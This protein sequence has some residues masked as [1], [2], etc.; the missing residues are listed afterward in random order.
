MCDNSWNGLEVVNFY[1]DVSMVVLTFY[2][3]NNY[4]WIKWLNGLTV[5][6]FSWYWQ[7]QTINGHE[8]VNL[9]WWVCFEMM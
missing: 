9:C 6:K 1:N 5:V 3:I 7:L 2:N 4:V 8:K